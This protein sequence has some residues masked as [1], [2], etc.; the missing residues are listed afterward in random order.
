MEKVNPIIQEMA[1]IVTSYGFNAVRFSRLNE[2]GK[3]AVSD[4]MTT[5]LLKFISNKYNDMDFSE[6]EKSQGH[7]SKFKY[8]DIIKENLDT[9]EDIYK[10]H[11][12]KIYDDYIVSCRT[13]INHLLEE[14]RSYSQAFLNEIGFIQLNYTMMVSTLIY[15]VSTLVMATVR[16]ISIDNDSEIEVI[17]EDL[18]KHSNYVFMN[19][20][21]KYAGCIQTG[22]MKKVL[23]AFIAADAKTKQANESFALTI[24]TATLPMLAIPVII[25]LVW[26]LIPI[27]RELIYTIFFLRIKITDAINIQ[28]ELLNANIEAVDNGNAKNKK[29]IVAKQKRVVASLTALRNVF[30][31]KVEKAEPQMR[32]EI[33]SEDRE[34]KKKNQDMQGPSQ[35]TPE[36]MI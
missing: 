13:I 34:L 21:R 2:A 1:K 24:S 3:V 30:M 26:K 19:S 7:Y 9:L 15:T 29:K 14:E 17:V 5:D 16:F 25:I 28:I 11:D 12:S 22:E 4:E 10:T 8:A 32:R 31:L 20:S 6:I 33:D 35:K 18:S 27:I 23:N 36:I